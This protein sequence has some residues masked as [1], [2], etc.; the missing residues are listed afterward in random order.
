MCHCIR[1]ASMSW[2]LIILCLITQTPFA[3][4]APGEVLTL[5]EAERLSL[6]DEPGM[7][8]FNA[9]AEALA[10]RA[11]A[12]AQLPDPK[13]RFGLMNFPT[14]TFN[15]TQEPMT[16]VQLGIQQAFPRGDSLAVKARRTE[17]LS[18]AQRELATDRGLKILQELR[19]SWLE[20]YYWLG[21]QLIIEQNRGLFTQLV[22]VTQHQYAVGKHN[23]QDV[24]RAQLELS[25]L[26]DRLEKIGI[27]Q[28]QSRAE[29]GRWLGADHGRRPLPEQFPRLPELADRGS[30]EAALIEHPLIRADR[31]K[32]IAG[33]QAV[34]LAREAYKP[35]WALGV[36]YGFRGG[37]TPNGRERA[38]F[39]S[40]SVTVDLP[41]FRDK[42]QDRSLAAS[43]YELEAMRFA[44][45]E[46]LRELRQK[47][48]SHYAQWWRL[49]ERA[50]LY[51]NT[52]QTQA[53]ENAQA[54]LLAYQ[55]DNADFAALTRARIT[56]LDTQLKAL[57]IRVDRAKAQARLLY[58]A[59]DVQ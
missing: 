24:I 44:R 39:L 14:D 21:A 17:V 2:V 7:A 58:L 51:A 41:I 3:R 26:D 34:A 49:G 52:L 48:D 29:L 57:R 37:E 55:N 10:Q 22:Q 42:R 23:Q 4:E 33:Q 5:G 9:S 11:T 53:Q 54:S 12:D 45:D 27:R 15:R 13:F 1:R 20:L 35:G 18:G 25:L 56:E 30:L 19:L 6:E 36:N 8:R 59:G 47:L 43:Q 16:Q 31:S 40:A 32:V 46:R 38:D 28:E 50:A